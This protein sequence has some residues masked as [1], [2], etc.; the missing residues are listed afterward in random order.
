MKRVSQNLNE[1]DY[2]TLNEWSLPRSV[3]YEF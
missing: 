3:F 1:L 2:I